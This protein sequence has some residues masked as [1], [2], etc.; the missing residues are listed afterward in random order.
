MKA[1]VLKRELDLAGL[2]G[3][4]PAAGGTRFAG[5]LAPGHPQARDHPQG[6]A[7]QHVRRWRETAATHPLPG[8]GRGL[9]RRSSRGACPW[10]VRG[11]VRAHLLADPRRFA[12][13]GRTTIFAAASQLATRCSAKAWRCLAGDALLTFAFELVAKANGWPRYGTRDLVAE[14]AVTAGSLKLI[15][16]QVADLEGEGQP[17]TPRQLRY[18]HRVQD[19]GAVD[20]RHPVRRHERQRRR[21]GTGRAERP[22]AKRWD[23]R[24]RSS[25]TFWTSRKPARS[26]ARAPARICPRRRPRIRPCSASTK[27]VT[28]RADSRRKRTLR[29][30]PLEPARR[31]CVL[32]PTICCSANI[33]TRSRQLHA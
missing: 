3:A 11:R 24:S 4:T 8:R 15:A 31:H 21:Q 10:R 17:V 20:D 27:P 32:W 5:R 28:R 1:A 12:E 13:H 30:A 16:G 26:W 29:W 2:S 23:S 18:I 14:L 7:L 33:R 22:S 19:G 9:R 25:T 6:H